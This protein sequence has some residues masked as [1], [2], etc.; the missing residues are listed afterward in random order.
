MRL[1]SRVWNELPQHERLA[2]LRHCKT[3]MTESI[4][5]HEST[6]D[7][8]KLWPMRQDELCDVDAE[9]ILKRELQP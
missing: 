6:L 2:L 3:G 1:M 4:M 8:D 5:Q 7:W 9:S